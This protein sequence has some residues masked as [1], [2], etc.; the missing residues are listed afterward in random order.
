LQKE[1]KCHMVLLNLF[2]GNL[3]SWKMILFKKFSRGE[4]S[5]L[6]QPGGS[7]LGLYV[8]KMVVE[9]VHEGKTPH[10]S[11]INRDRR[12][13]VNSQYRLRLTFL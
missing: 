4:G 6:V 7:G 10:Q 2:L 8:A 13:G 11:C 3:I 12:L 1:K 9:G 5:F